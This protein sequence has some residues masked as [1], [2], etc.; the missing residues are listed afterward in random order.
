VVMPL[1]PLFLG[2]KFVGRLANAVLAATFTVLVGA[3]AASAQSV[4]SL[5]SAVV[6]INTAWSWFGRWK[7]PPSP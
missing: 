2:Y 1:K 3:S 5:V 7:P 4:E 6:K